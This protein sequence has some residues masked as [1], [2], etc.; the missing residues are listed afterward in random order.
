[1]RKI[2]LL[3]TIF[4]LLI[5]AG[6]FSAVIINKN[7]EVVFTDSPVENFIPKA[8]KIT[9][10]QTEKYKKPGKSA[11]LPNPVHT[12]QTFNNCGPATLSMALGFYGTKVSQQELGLAMRPYQNP[13]GDNDDKTIFSSEFVYW[14]EKHGMN[15]QTRVNG[16]VDT[17]KLFTANGIPVVVKTW[18]NPGEDIGHFRLIRGFDEERGVII[19]DD[20]YQGKDREI[21]YDVFLSMWQPFNYDYTLVYP[22]EKEQLVQAIIGNESE[23]VVMWTNS[24]ERAKKESQIEPQNIYPWFNMSVSYFHLGKFDKSIAA[25]EEVQNRLPG[26]MLW[27]QIEPIEAYTKEGEWDTALV[28]IDKILANNNRAF[29]ELYILK[30]D[31]YKIQGDL[32]NARRQY[33]LAVF[34]NSN[35]PKAQDKLQSI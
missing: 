13:E 28:L 19:Q 30:G 9:P 7:Q 1:M 22:P 26:R 32:S 33:E 34:Y 18:L 14:A 29:S 27:Y 25:F 4:T 11:L 35:L 16:T 15:S 2:F 23:D 5:I 6:L 31:W 21:N 17:L 24:L 8:N 10:T 12:F 20:S 3:P